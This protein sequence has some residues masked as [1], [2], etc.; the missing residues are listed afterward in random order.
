MSA[1]NDK[2]IRRIAQKTAAKEQKN[3]INGFLDVNQGKILESTLEI[4]KGM[5]FT[6]RVKIACKIVRGRK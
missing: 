4:I 3:I 6:A 5:K 2:T 1:K